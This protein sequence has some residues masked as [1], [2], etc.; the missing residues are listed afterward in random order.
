MTK[1][2]LRWAS[3][4]D[5]YMSGNRYGIVVRDYNN[6]AEVVPVKFTDFK[7]LYIWAGY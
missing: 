4:H 1:S 2:Q 6:K 3:K 5:W 7:S